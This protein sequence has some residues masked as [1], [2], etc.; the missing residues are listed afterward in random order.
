MAC[1]TIYSTTLRRKNWCIVAL[2]VGNIA[3]LVRSKKGTT[4]GKFVDFVALLHTIE[5]TNWSTKTINCITHGTPS[6]EATCEL[7]NDPPIKLAQLIEGATVTQHVPA[8][9]TVRSRITTDGSHPQMSALLDHRSR[10][11]WSKLLTQLTNL[12]SQYQTEQPIAVPTDVPTTMHTSYWRQN[13]WSNISS[14]RKHAG[15]P[16]TAVR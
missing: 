16:E 5:N 12:C 15:S 8:P 11:R 14:I 9:A 2:V 6:D 3:L 13:S 7:I 1:G 4:S 10:L